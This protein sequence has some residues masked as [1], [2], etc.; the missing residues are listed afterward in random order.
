MPYQD[1]PTPSTGNYTYL[2]GQHTETAV[3][4]PAADGP[5][6]W[7]YSIRSYIYLSPMVQRRCLDGRLTLNRIYGQAEPGLGADACPVSA[8]RP[9]YTASGD[10]SEKE[11]GS[12]PQSQIMMTMMG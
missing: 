7:P 2:R 1:R 4:N 8:R 12:D 10:M 11:G 6:V 3:Q 5:G 9:Q